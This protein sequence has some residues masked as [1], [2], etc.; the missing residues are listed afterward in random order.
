[1]RTIANQVGAAFGKLGVSG[2][3]ELRAKAIQEM[4]TVRQQALQVA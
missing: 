2:R 3:P 4:A 1:M